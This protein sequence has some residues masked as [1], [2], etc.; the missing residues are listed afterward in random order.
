MEHWREVREQLLS[1]TYQPKP[2]LDRRFPSAT[3]EC[4]NS[5][6]RACSTG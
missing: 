4:V 6:F 2:V 1:G 5:V 3:V